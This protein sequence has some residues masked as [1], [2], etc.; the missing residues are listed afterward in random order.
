M[1]ARAELRTRALKLLARGAPERAAILLREYLVLRREDLYAHE[2]LIRCFYKHEASNR[3]ADFRNFYEGELKLSWSSPL[4]NFVQAERMVRE[5]RLEPALDHYRAALGAGLN[6]PTGRYRYGVALCAANKQDEGIEHIRAALTLDPVYLPALDVYGKILLNQAHFI[7]LERLFDTANGSMNRSLAAAFVDGTALQARL[8]RRYEATIGLKESIRLHES[9]NSKAALER[10]WPV[11]TQFPAH[12]VLL[13]T[14]IYLFHRCGWLATGCSRVEEVLSSG[15]PAMS[16]CQGLVHWYENEEQR[17]LQRLS[18]AIDGGVDQPLVRFARALALL[19]L[20]R[21][22]EAYEDLVNGYSREP[23]LACIRCELAEFAYHNQDYATVLDLAQLSSEQRHAARSYEIDGASRMGRLD[24]VALRTYTTLDDLDAGIRWIAMVDSLPTDAEY[25]LQ[26]SM[27]Q[28]GVGDYANAE[29]LLVRAIEIDDDIIASISDRELDLIDR[30][31]AHLPSSLGAELVHAV[32][33][34]YEGHARKTYHLLRKLVGRFPEHICVWYCLGRAARAS[35]YKNAARRAFE[36]CVALDKRFRT[37]IQALESCLS[38]ESDI[39][40][41]LRLS[42]L[43]NDSGP[44]ESALIIA[45]KSDDPRQKDIARTL[46]S[47]GPKDLQTT[48]LLGSLG[49]AERGADV[50]RAALQH[51]CKWEFEGR[52]TI[53]CEMLARG[54][55]GDAGTAYEDLISDGGVR[56]GVLETVKQ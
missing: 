52:N 24:C 2:Q 25:H 36:R 1:T 33:P 15:E 47:R 49:D 43:V 5:N 53:A 13:R 26:A 12:C 28:A 45:H 30:M 37:G 23:G 22:R 18:D 40:G 4:G 32:R 31:Q 38:K 56:P 27:I 29:S 9:E 6:H 11:W 46:L 54:M 16:Y 10:L 20:K 19:A 48:A 44:A 3:T 51:T 34:A 17:A 14:L 41:L 7:Q 55:G 39:D 50:L 21:S 8:Q 42:E 35:G